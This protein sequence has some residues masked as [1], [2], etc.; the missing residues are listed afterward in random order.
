MKLEDRG[1][2]DLLYTVAWP[3]NFNMS[4]ES[5][6]PNIQMLQDLTNLALSSPFVTPARLVFISSIG[7]LRSMSLCDVSLP[8][9]PTAL[10]LC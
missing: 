6:E 2:A 3:V 5:F 4:L 8:S 10:T 7:V 1:R 9:I